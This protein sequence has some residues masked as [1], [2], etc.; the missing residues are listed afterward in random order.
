MAE[1]RSPGS[2]GS[3]SFTESAQNAYDVVVVGEAHRLT[4]KSGFCGN[5]GAQ[6]IQAL[7]NAA[8]CSVFLIDEDQRVTLK[9]IGT[10]GGHDHQEHLP[11]LDDPWD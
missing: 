8:L 5:L 1:P 6:Q 10:T 11:H 7:I 4:E 9:D 2:R 3:G